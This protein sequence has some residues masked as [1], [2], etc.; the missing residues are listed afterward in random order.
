MTQEKNF[1]EILFQMKFVTEPTESVRIIGNLPEMGN[2]DPAKGLVLKQQS[3]DPT[4][5]A[6]PNPLRVEKSLFFYWIFTIFTHCRHK[7]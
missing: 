4:L 7:N 6:S 2:W 3:D 1:C 5:W